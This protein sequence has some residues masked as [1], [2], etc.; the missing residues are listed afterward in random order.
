MLQLPLPSVL[1]VFYIGLLVQPETISLCLRILVCE[2][3]IGM[4][5][6]KL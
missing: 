5:F 1:G 2:A 6:G 4:A 3:L